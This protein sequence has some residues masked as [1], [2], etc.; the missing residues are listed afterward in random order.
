MYNSQIQMQLTHF[1]SHK[2]TF[3][4]GPDILTA[5]AIIVIAI[6]GVLEYL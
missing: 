5:L 2:I 1:E 3:K 6:K 4:Y